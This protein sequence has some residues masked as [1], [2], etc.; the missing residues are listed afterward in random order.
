MYFV[1]FVVK[2]WKSINLDVI[3]GIRQTVC[4]NRLNMLETAAKVNCKMKNIIIQIYEVQEPGEAEKLINIGVDH[5]GS[6]IL[7][8]ADWKI[9][10]VKKAIEQVRSSAAKSCLI[11]LYNTPD[12][13]MRTLDFYQPDIVHFCE[14][15]AG[16]KDMEAHCRR[17]I[18]LQ[19]DV[20]RRFPQL[21]I[22]RSIPIAQENWRHLVPTLDIAKL[23]EP[24]SDFFLTDTLLINGPISG[25]DSQPVQGFVRR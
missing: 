24:T 20:K 23:F 25:A 22:M 13:V 8:E 5:I 6:V 9:D 21:E 10:G 7:S 14:A 17:L 2:Y 3:P 15:L 18:Q 4:E 16:H 19:A 11:P 1:F 12:S